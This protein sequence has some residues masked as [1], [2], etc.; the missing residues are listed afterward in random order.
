MCGPN[1]D[2]DK[3]KK[4]VENREQAETKNQKH[5]DIRSGCGCPSCGDRP[6]CPTNKSDDN[7]N[8]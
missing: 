4:D 6:G 2:Y 7:K 5:E 8:K 1:K 3:N